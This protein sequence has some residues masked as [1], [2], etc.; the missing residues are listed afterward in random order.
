MK[1][2]LFQR[3]QGKE[4]SQMLRR[5]YSD[6][7]GQVAQI[8]LIVALAIIV[9]GVVAAVGGPLGSAVADFVDRMGKFF[10]D[11]WDRFPGFS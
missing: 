11:L 5:F 9:I 1:L 3:S 7:R 8:I 6:E 4:V 2:R 10:T